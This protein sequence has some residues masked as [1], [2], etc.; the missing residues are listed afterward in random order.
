MDD[1][2]DTGSAKNHKADLEVIQSIKKQLD[3]CQKKLLDTTGKNKLVNFNIP[4]TEEAAAKKGILRFASASD[5]LSLNGIIKKLREADSRKEKGLLIVPVRDFTEQEKKEFHEK[6]GKEH[7]GAKHESAQDEIGDSQEADKAKARAEALGISCEYE[8]G[9]SQDLS[10]AKNSS[11]VFQTILNPKVLESCLLK[12]DAKAKEVER[13]TGMNMLFLSF[14]VLKFKEDNATSAAAWKRAPLWLVPVSLRKC[15]ELNKE[16]GRFDFKIELNGDDEQKNATLGRLLEDLY[17]FEPPGMPGHSAGE[18]SGEANE[19]FDVEKYLQAVEEKIK[20]KKDWKVERIITLSLF[21]YGKM[22]LHKKLDYHEYPALLESEILRDVLCGRQAEANEKASKNI[23]NIDVFR[24]SEEAAASGLPG[25]HLSLETLPFS[26][27]SSQHLSIIDVLNGKS[28]VI[29]GPPGTGKSQTIANVIAASMLGGKKVLF[30]SE[31]QAALDVVKSRLDREGLGDFCLDMHSGAGKKKKIFEEIKKTIETIESEENP[32]QDKDGKNFAEKMSDMKERRRILNE[33][34]KLKDENVGSIGKTLREALADLARIRSQM[35]E[36]EKR[37]GI[38]HQSDGIP[39]GEI[40]LQKFGF[41]ENDS[42]I[43]SARAF[44]PQEFKK[45]S[46][47]FKDLA[48]RYKKFSDQKRLS[49]FSINDVSGLSEWAKVKKDREDAASLGV[50]SD[51]IYGIIDLKKNLRSAISDVLKKGFN[52]AELESEL[53]RALDSHRGKI[54]FLKDTK[55]FLSSN[56]AHQK[57]T[58]QKVEYIKKANNAW[59]HKIKTLQNIP[60]KLKE[61][62]F[63]TAMLELDAKAQSFQSAISAIESALAAE[64][65]YKSSASSVGLDAS[66]METLKGILN[67]W[68]LMSSDSSPKDSKDF[69]LAR[70]LYLKDTKA[71]EV[72]EYNKLKTAKEKADRVFILDHFSSNRESLRVD[73]GKIEESIQLMEK[74]WIVRKL[75]GSEKKAKAKIAEFAKESEITNLSAELEPLLF[76]IKGK[77]RFELFPPGFIEAIKSALK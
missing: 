69:D 43:E 71:D 18:N 41:F 67:L 44:G 64:R 19:D 21:H 77:I 32:R 4:D 55:S 27:D 17:G 31:K 9:R 15:K 10:R 63:K 61:M 58:A 72:R 76:F 3:E 28:L 34:L 62:D 14:G 42:I 8:F 57:I 53:S 73:I 35:V 7:S 16:T 39:K 36:N 70:A 12:I 47:V 33:C 6:K 51:I 23:E 56:A 5:G 52:K 38:K 26:A 20:G 24:E 2:E 48:D 22:A 59:E 54:E 46:G 13:E 29:Q 1:K 75:I 65:E 66:D 30:I 49:D 11:I 60:E 74:S 37:C 45:L 68:D 50:A 40:E 25:Y